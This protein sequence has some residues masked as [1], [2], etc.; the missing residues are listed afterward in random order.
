MSCVQ[1]DGD[2]F[3]LPAEQYAI[4]TGNDPREFTEKN[5]STFKRPIKALGLSYDWDREIATCDPEYYRWT[6]WIFIQLYKR[7]L[8]ELK[9]VEVN[10]CE[11]L[12]TVLANEEVI[13]VDGK[14]VSERGNHPVEKRPMRQWVLKITE[15]AERLLQDLESLDWPE[16]IKD[17]QRNWIGKSTGALV[18]FKVAGL[19]DSFTVFTTRPDTLFGQT[20]CVLPRACTSFKNH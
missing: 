8:A 15:Y 7:G 14:M 2:A 19:D 6:Q 12:G 5:I 16:S 1:W 3:G 10:W 4:E 13:N 17:M 20:Y 9:E 18:N 11:G